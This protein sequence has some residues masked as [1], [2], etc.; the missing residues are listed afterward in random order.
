MLLRQSDLLY[1]DDWWKLWQWLT[2]HFLRQVEWAQLGT[3]WWVV[4]ALLCSAVFYSL[5]RN[6]KYTYVLPGHTYHVG[7]PKESLAMRLAAKGIP[8]LLLPTII[9]LLLAL[10]RP[11]QEKILTEQESEGVSIVL[12]LDVS[13]SMNLKDFLPNRLAV[14]KAVAKDFLKGRQSDEIGIVVFAGD[15]LTLSPLTTDYAHLM[16]RIDEIDFSIVMQRGTAVGTAIAV[17]VN[18][19]EQAKTKSKVLLILSDGDNTAGTL[20][21]EAAALIAKEYGVK[22]YSILIGKEGAVLKGNDAFGQP[23]YVNNTVDPAAMEAIARLTGGKYYRAEDRRAL[24]QVFREINRLE[25][26]PIKLKQ[27]KVVVEYYAIYLRWALVF[28]LL[29]Y[30]LRFSPWRSWLSD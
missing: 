12:L 22:I 15:A 6:E 13:S 18:R 28:L 20:E 9:M 14:M 24:S 27:V 7:T 3:W 19:L 29:W 16:Q 11:Q 21:P 25:K 23:V 17:G 5:F 10:A 1:T 30:A 26:S 8:F 4:A 2:P